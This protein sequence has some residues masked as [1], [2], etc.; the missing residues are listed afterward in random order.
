MKLLATI[1][2]HLLLIASTGYADETVPRNPFLYQDSSQPIIHFNSAQ[3]DAVAAAMPMGR[4]TVTPQQVKFLP[5]SLAIPG[6]VHKTYD[7]GTA[8]LLA[9]TNS[10][11]MKLRVDGGRFE[12]IDEIVLPGFEKDYASPEVVDAL[13]KKLDASYMN[14]EVVLSELDR[15]MKKYNLGSDNAPN[16]LYTMV[17]KDGHLYAGYGTTIFKIGDVDPSQ[18]ANSK[19]KVLASKDVRTLLPPELA[20]QSRRRQQG[21]LLFGD[22]PAAQGRPILVDHG[23]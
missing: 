9:S 4:V 6:T 11:V 23:L 7:D 12:K 15:Y 13:L 19:I 2:A 22:V 20:L 18:T 3:T 14:D 10:S 1:L 17:D 5:A 16:G 8:V 21:Y